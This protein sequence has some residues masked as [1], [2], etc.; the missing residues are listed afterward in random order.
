MDE[1]EIV[2]GGTDAEEAAWRTQA[3]DRGA[4][5]VECACTGSGDEES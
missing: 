4:E 1:K 3:H 2:Q 5:S